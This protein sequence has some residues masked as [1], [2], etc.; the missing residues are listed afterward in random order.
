MTMASPFGYGVVE[1][2][3]YVK[4]PAWINPYL[5]SPPHSCVGD[6]PFNQGGAA[7]L[8]TLQPDGM[9]RSGVLYPMPMAGLSKAE[10]MKLIRERLANAALKPFQTQSDKQATKGKRARR[11]GES[12]QKLIA[13]DLQKIGKP[14][15]FDEHAIYSRAVTGHGED[16]VFDPYTWNRFGRLVIEA[17]HYKRKMDVQ[18]IFKQHAQKRGLKKKYDLNG[19]PILVYR[20]NYEPIMAV[21]RQDDLATLSGNLPESRLGPEEL[22]S[23]PWEEVLQLLSRKVAAGGPIGPSVEPIFDGEN[24]PL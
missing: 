20:F 18:K 16:I 9:S 17:K 11:K 23:V 1:A 6:G 15:G 7:L 3:L 8:H 13:A 24:I 4:A 19:I 5:F 12:F 2:F 21:I 10:R 14:Y 22:V